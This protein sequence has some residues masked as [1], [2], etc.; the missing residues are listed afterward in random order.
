MVRV[1]VVEL[2]AASLAV[3]VMV[4]SS[5]QWRGRAEIV[6]SVVPEAVPLP[7]RLLVQ[8]TLVTPHGTRTDISRPHL[9]I[10][11]TKIKGCGIYYRIFTNKQRGDYHG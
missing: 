11:L 3:I 10:Y 2:S 1:S 8:V 6:Q 9:T 7:P 5:P 4:L